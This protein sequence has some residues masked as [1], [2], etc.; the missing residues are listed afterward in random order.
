MKKKESLVLIL[1]L[2]MMLTACGHEHT[3]QAATCVSPKI[4]PE[5]GETEGEALGHSWIEATCTEAKV[6]AMCLQTMGEPLGH[7]WIDAT[8]TESK[9]CAV[10]NKQEGDPLGHEWT[11][12]DCVTAETCSVCGDTQGEPVR[13]EV[14]NWTVTMDSTCTEVGTE[15]GTCN[16]C[17]ESLEREIEKKEHVAGEWVV[18]VQP[19]I[20][21]DGQRTR[22]CVTC[23]KELESESYTLSDEEIERLY[24]NNCKSIAYDSLARSPGEYEGEYVKFSGRVVQVCS[25]AS[26]ALY[27]STYRVA[28]SGSYNSVVYIYVDNYGSGERILEDDWITFYGKFD[29]LFSYETVMGAQVTIP[30]VKVEY[31]D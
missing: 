25:E 9:H 12:A 1:I 20:D 17:G 31:V 4:C 22:S 19:T 24:K 10:C 11:A 16:H 27:Y 7:E 26:S 15:S 23:Q 21:E 18:T 2:L 5:C 30:S 6:C 14:E 29:G 3:W 13:H 28:V 8:C